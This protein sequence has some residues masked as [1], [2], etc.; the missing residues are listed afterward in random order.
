MGTFRPGGRRSILPLSKLWMEKVPSREGE[1]LNEESS[2]S[3][4]SVY[5]V[6]EN[7]TLSLPEDSQEPDNVVLSSSSME[8]IRRSLPW[9]AP[10][11]ELARAGTSRGWSR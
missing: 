5:V 9:R 7:S 6:V 2:V 8:F 1:P 3:C 10:R 11:A 4:E